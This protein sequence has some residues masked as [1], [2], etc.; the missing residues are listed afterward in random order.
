MSES[1]EANVEI[2]GSE[3]LNLWKREFEF[4]EAGV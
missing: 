1:V 3:E 2:R 4:V